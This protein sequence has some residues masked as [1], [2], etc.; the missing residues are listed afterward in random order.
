V[1]NWH[2]W[3]A[4][5]GQ[6]RQTARAITGAANLIFVLLALSGLY[7]WWPRTWTVAAVRNI[8]LFRRRLT[9]KARDFNWHN[10]FGFWMAIPIVLVAGSGVVISYPWASN[11]VYRAA[12]E[13]PPQRGAAPAPSQGADERRGSRSVADQTTSVR[14]SADTTPAATPDAMLAAA[15]AREPDWTAISFRI[16]AGLAPVAVSIDRGTGGQPQ[17]KSTLTLNARSGV[18]EHYERFSD[19]SRGRR[20]RSWLRF[21]HTGE[22]GGFWGQTL[23][24][25]ASFAGI[26]LVYSGFALSWRRF[27]RRSTSTATSSRRHAA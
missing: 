2:R 23:A 13:A 14:G 25:M 22:A 9:P 18:E 11:L 16:T 20:W 5:E 27:F 3:L 1:T 26:V 17:R 19:Q 7:L 8:T 12:G 10:V 6:S 21:I 4:L 15:M 24:G